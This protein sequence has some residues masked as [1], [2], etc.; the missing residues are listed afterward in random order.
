[1]GLPW[2]SH[3]AKANRDTKMKRLLMKYG[4]EGYG[5]YW[6][7]VEHVADNVGPKL[8][9]EVEHDSEILAHELKIDTLK[10]EEMMLYMV[11]IGLFERSDDLITCLSLLKHLTPNCTRNEELKTLIRTAK[12]IPMSGT[13]SDSHGQSQT[14]T[15]IGEDKRREKQSSAGDE[16]TEKFEHWWAKYPNKQGKA[17]ALKLFLKMKVDDRELMLADDAERRY[18]GREKQYI[19]MGSTYVSEERFRDEMPKSGRVE[20]VI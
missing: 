13:V 7:C 6:Y 11:N 12:N 10:V 1:M 4:A 16:W 17:R 3:E 2:F 20:I 19:P 18:R 15:L 9:F 14:V 5:L 8:T